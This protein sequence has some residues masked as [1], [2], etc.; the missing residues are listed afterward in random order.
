[1]LTVSGLGGGLVLGLVVALV[2]AVAGIGA[3]VLSLEKGAAVQRRRVRAG[4]EALIGHHGIVRSWS[5]P[6]GSVLVDGALWKARRAL[7]DEQE[8]QLHAGDS[9]IVE[10]LTG[11]T[12]AV[13]RAEDWELTA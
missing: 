12:L 4:P 9:V 10:R 13:R 6:T 3:L 5:E 1:V 2:L 8:D 11:L 7:S